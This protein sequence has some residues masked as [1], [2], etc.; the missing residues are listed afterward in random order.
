MVHV[1]EYTARLDPK[2]THLWNC[3]EDPEV[4]ITKLPKVHRLQRLDQQKV[5][6]FC[7]NVMPLY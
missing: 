2:E 1:I 6:Y 3:K 7:N 4:Y 5:G